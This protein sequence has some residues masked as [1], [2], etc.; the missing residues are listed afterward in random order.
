M[1]EDVSRWGPEFGYKLLGRLK[2]DCDYFLGNGRGRE[3]DLWAG[4]VERQIAKMRSLMGSLPEA[5]EWLTAEEVDGYEREM[6]GMRVGIAPPVTEGAWSDACWSAAMD[7]FRAVEGDIGALA[8]GTFSFRD[9]Y[10]LR[11]GES[12][13]DALSAISY[14]Y[15]YSKSDDVM[16]EVG[17]ALAREG[18]SV[19]ADGLAD[20]A[21][22]LAMGHVRGDRDWADDHF[23]E[24]AATNAAEDAGR[25]VLGSRA[26]AEAKRLLR[27][28]REGSDF[29]NPE[30]DLLVISYLAHPDP[31]VQ[32]FSLRDGQ[33]DEALPQAG[34][35]ASAGGDEQVRLFDVA[36]ALKLSGVQPFLEASGEEDLEEV[37]LRMAQAPGRWATG[38]VGPVAAIVR[39]ADP[40]SV[41]SRAGAAAARSVRDAAGGAGPVPRA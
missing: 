17:A 7:A 27:Q 19:D 6:S 38:P 35:I 41:A 15:F 34:R 3:E 39:E 24:R 16:A 22:S 4:S 14:L 36:E 31:S 11:G 13:I 18:R 10:A 23:A 2:A 40:E 1:D 32:V 20:I 30:A 28:M 26:K 9:L 33:F 21:M 29:Y 12:L 5:P 37:A 8:D 25:A